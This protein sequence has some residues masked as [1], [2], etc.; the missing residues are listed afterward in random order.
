MHQR[1]SQLTLPLTLI[2]AALASPPVAPAAEPLERFSAFAVDLGGITSRGRAGTVD[3]VIERWSTPEEQKRLTDALGENGSD[4][5]LRALRKVE[6]DTGYIRG[7]G[8]GYP[9]RFAAQTPLPGG[10]R[11]ILIATDRPISFFEARNRPITVDEY[12][13]MVIDMRLNAKGEGDGKL[14]PVARIR[15]HPD[16]VIEVENYLQQPVRLTKVR[17]VT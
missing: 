16:H 3:I 8:L 7:R 17:K 9:L 12:P 14:L 1:A 2:A 11:R 5:L 13:F 6:P 4:G 10:G 15:Q